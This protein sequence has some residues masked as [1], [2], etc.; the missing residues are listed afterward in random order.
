MFVFTYCFLSISESENRLTHL[1]IAERYIIFITITNLNPTSR[2]IS[3]SSSQSPVLI[4]ISQVYLSHYLNH[5]SESPISINISVIHLN[6]LSQSP[7]NIIHL[8]HHLNLNH[9]SQSSCQYKLK[10]Q[11]SLKFYHAYI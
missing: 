4:N 6:H 9:S 3:Q 1:P 5:Q 8:N 7:V 10:R 2:S 11:I